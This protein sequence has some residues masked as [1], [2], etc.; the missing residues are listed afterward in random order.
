MCLQVMC[1]HPS[2]RLIYWGLVSQEDSEHGSDERAGLPQA[3]LESGVAGC[4]AR[5]QEHN[6]GLV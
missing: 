5:R 6:L 3:Q 1:K 4:A 2:G